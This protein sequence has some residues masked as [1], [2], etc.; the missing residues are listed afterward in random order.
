ML[1]GGRAL[2]PLGEL[3]EDDK[4]GKLPVSL[5]EGTCL[6]GGC[7]SNGGWVLRGGLGGEPVGEPLGGFKA[8]ELLGELRDRWMAGKLFPS[9][10]N[11]DTQE[12]AGM[13]RE[14]G[15]RGGVGWGSCLASYWRAAGRWSCLEGVGLQRFLSGCWRALGHWSCMRSCWRVRGQVS[16]LLCFWRAGIKRGRWYQ[17]GEKRRSGEG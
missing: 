4:A 16:C 7:V 12:A 8:Y 14:R 11:S 1:D 6:G 2:E 10:Q 5:L 13:K 15:G 9:L 17:D 3:L